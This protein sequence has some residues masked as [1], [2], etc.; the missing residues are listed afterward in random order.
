[1]RTFRILLLILPFISP[2]SAQQSDLEPLSQLMIT[3]LGRKQFDSVYHRFS[4]DLRRQLSLHRI[5]SSWEHFEEKYGAL[6]SK[7]ESVITPKDSLWISETKIAFESK[8][9][10]VQLTFNHRSEL[11]GFFIRNINLPYSPPDYAKP[12]HFRE[13]HLT[14]AAKGYSNKGILSLPVNRGRYPLVIISGGS[15]PTDMDGTI[16]PNKPYQDIAW[17]LASG[18]IAVYRF[19]KRTRNRDN[20]DT[21]KQD[22]FGVKEEY[23]DDMIAVVDYFRRHEQ[24]NPGEIYILGHSQGG[25]M[26]PAF[27]RSMGNKVKGY[28]NLAGNYSTLAPMLEYQFGYFKQQSSD[29]AAIAAYESLIAKARYM[30]Q[31]IR[32]KHALKDSLIPGLTPYYLEDMEDH[33]PAMLVKHLYNKNVLVIHGGRDYQVPVPEAEAW[34]KALSSSCCATFK[35]FGKL[36]HI[37][38]EGE[39][40]STPAEYDKQQNIPQYLTDYISEWVLKPRK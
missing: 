30:Q 21:A 13:Y 29:S 39:G 31:N 1:M 32:N 35:V 36:N 15:G 28:I 2:A 16:G 18:N 26:L 10:I 9:F 19:D 34:E 6:V 8:S 25:Y 24:I 12:Q 7:G 40:L 22:R 23:I 38:Q 27:A 11:C 20:L 3:Q 5:E 14:V 33:S 37:M 17:A 4:E